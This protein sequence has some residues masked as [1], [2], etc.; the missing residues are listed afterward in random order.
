MQTVDGLWLYPSREILSPASIQEILDYALT[1]KVQTIVFNKA[2]LDWG[3]LLSVGSNT[4]DVAAAAA[5]LLDDLLGGN[6]ASISRMKPLTSVETHLN[7]DIAQ[8]LGVTASA[9]GE[10]R[11]ELLTAIEDDS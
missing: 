8:K 10:V 4:E 3:A 9:P 5:E 6:S 2:L 1:H 7:Q 11:H